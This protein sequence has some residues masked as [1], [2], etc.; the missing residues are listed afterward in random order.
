M[1]DMTL[2]FR[3]E[4]ILPVEAIPTQKGIR[5]RL[6][7]PE[8]TQK[9]MAQLPADNVLM[10][11]AGDSLETSGALLRA[12]GLTPKV[13]LRK[14]PLPVRIPKGAEQLR[15]IKELM[16]RDMERSRVKPGRML[17]DITQRL[18]ARI[19]IRRGPGLMPLD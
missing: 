8:P 19:P 15:P 5:P 9:G 2:S 10:L 18:M 17:R 1:K 13:F 4:A 3:L 16:Q 14:H 11:K 12:M 6:P 7:D